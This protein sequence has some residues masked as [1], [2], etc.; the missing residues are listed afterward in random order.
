MEGERLRLLREEHKGIVNQLALVRNA[1]GQSR[2]PP[3]EELLELISGLMSRIVKHFADEEKSVYRPLGRKLGEDSPTHQLMSE[4][5]S[6]R[7]GFGMLVRMCAR[8]R[9]RGRSIKGVRHRF[10]SLREEL[11]QHIKKEES[12]LYWLA[13]VMLPSRM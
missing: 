10:D 1:I 5:E 12:V 8:Y 3:P 7:R 11:S 6:L 2:S 4:H 13:D 9:G